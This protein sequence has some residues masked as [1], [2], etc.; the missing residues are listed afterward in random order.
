MLIRIIPLLIFCFITITFA[1]S[2]TQTDWSGGDG[3]IGPV[4]DW[5]TSF[6]ADTDIQC[7]T[8]PS[9]LVLLHLDHTVDGD[10]KGACS[11]HSADVNG[12][13]YIDVLGAAYLADDITWWENLDGSGTSWTEHTVD[14]DFNR[15]LSVYSADINGDGYIDV[16]G[17]ASYADDITW[18][19][20]VDG[21]GT[22][23]TE[24]TVDWDFDGAY[25]VHS[26]DVN[27]DGYIDV[28]GAASYADDITWWE[29][30]DGSGTNWTEHTVDGDFDDALSVHSADVNGDGYMDVLGAASYADDITWWENSDTSPG[31]IWTEHTVDGDFDGAYSV[32][33]ADVNGDGYMDVLGAAFTADDITWWENVDGSGTSWTEHTVDGDFDHA[34]SVYSAD[35]NG[36]GYIDILG[37]ASYADDITWWENVDGSGTNWTEHF[38]DGDFKGP[39]SVY[40][41]DINGDG[42]IDVL[43]A[44]VRA[45]D[46]T[47]WDLNA[48]LPDGS[49]ES[50]ILDTECY[51]QWASID[52]SSSEPAGTDLYFQYRTSDDPGSMGSW[53]DTIPEPCNLSGLLDRYFQYR[54]SLETDDPG[55]TP[56]LNDVTLNWDPLG[57]EGDP[58]VTEY[59]LLGIIPNP[60]SLPAV[61][62]CLP[63]P[64]FVELSIFDLSGRLLRKINGEDYSLGYHDVLLGELSQGIYF[65]RMI[66][67]EFA[68]TQRFVVIE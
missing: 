30:V 57:I 33:S 37:A 7:Y 67:G 23:W 43:G 61:R 56:T 63:E 22:S 35:I 59:S 34:R 14:G 2:A 51:P 68:A 47:W 44:A 32:H 52:W 39:C 25:S 27:G 20:N 1:D 26:A 41:A 28:L 66:S 45:D 38:V 50:S 21:S 9:E 3:I 48:Y 42:Y 19:E 8:Y 60:S 55:S 15:A 10:F 6:Y 62:F 31:I 4:I 53:S 17:A 12:D 40:S 58:Q 54:V 24:H 13:G 65:C 29:N 16:L 5:S 36:D 64:A 18:W 11:V 49:L 46:I